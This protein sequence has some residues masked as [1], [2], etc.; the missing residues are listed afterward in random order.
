M[1]ASEIVAV[2]G[3]QAVTEDVH[4]NDA[5]GSGEASV[6]GVYCV[7]TLPNFPSHLILLPNTISV[8]AVG[9]VLPPSEHTVRRDR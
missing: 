6:G 4:A 1:A 2:A 7:G 9:C 8:S 5:T 3:G